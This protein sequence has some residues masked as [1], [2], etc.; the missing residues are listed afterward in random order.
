MEVDERRIG[1]P[2]G[3]RWLYAFLQHPPDFVTDGR[4]NVTAEINS[5]GSHS[6]SGSGS[7]TE[8]RSNERMCTLRTYKEW[9]ADMPR[10]DGFVKPFNY[11]YVLKYVHKYT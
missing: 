11:K 3:R 6:G 9:T 5:S 4:G 1:R 8:S 10:Y 7:G 2:K